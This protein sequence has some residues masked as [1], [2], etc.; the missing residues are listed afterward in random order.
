MLFALFRWKS[1]TQTSAEGIARLVVGGLLTLCAYK[2]VGG[3][4][5]ALGGAYAGELVKHVVAFF[6]AVAVAPAL[7]GRLHGLFSHEAR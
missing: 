4:A 7:F 6:T 2:L 1:A 5:V 3:A